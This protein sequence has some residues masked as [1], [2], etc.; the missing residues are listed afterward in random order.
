M[1]R[2][3]TCI[4]EHRSW[5]EGQPSENHELKYASILDF[6]FLRE[7]RFARSFRYPDDVGALFSLLD[8]PLPVAAFYPEYDQTQIHIDIIARAAWNLLR[9]VPESVLIAGL[10]YSISRTVIH[11]LI[12]RYASILSEDQVCSLADSLVR[13]SSPSSP[14]MFRETEEDQCRERKTELVTLTFEVGG[15]PS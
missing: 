8:T 4:K 13:S 11:E 12:H 2:K 3:R 6:T 9:G 7:S 1:N 15:R 10:A 5:C 14:K